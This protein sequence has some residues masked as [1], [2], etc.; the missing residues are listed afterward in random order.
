MKERVAPEVDNL[1][2][3]VFGGTSGIGA[4]TA[5]LLAA[6]GSQVL[7][8]GRR[9]R[10]GEDLAHSLGKRAA[11]IRCDVTLES[12]IAR[13]VAEA[14]DRFGGLNAVVNSAGGCACIFWESSRQ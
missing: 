13:A 4:R 1:R 7:I 8:A 9:Q 2:A 11:F 14:V 3:L 5:E 6:N 10:E 12:D